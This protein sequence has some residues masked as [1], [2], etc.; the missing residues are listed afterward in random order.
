MPPVWAY[1]FGDYR[2]DTVRRRLT[3]RGG[4]AL[5]LTPKAFDTLLFLLEHRNEILAKEDLL[6]ALWPGRIV[7]ENNVNQHISMLRRALGDT[8]GEHQYIV[9][10]PGRGYRFVADVHARTELSRSSE[11]QPLALAVL[12]FM[13][14]VPEQS[15][16]A[17]ELGMADTLITRLGGLRQVI[18][19]PLSSVRRFLDPARNP[20]EAGRSLAAQAVLDGSIQR[21][22]DTLRVTVRLLDVASE[23]A[24]W[25]ATFDEPV[26]GI[27]AV[28]D[29]IAA[30]VAGALALQ[31]G[32]QE[33]LHLARPL[34]ANPEAYEHYLNGRYHLARLTPPEMLTAVGHF[35]DAIA[36]EPAFALAHV[37]LASTLF[38][39]PLAGEKPPAEHFPQAQAAARS[40]LDIEPGLAEAHAVMGWVA[41]WFDWDWN[42][43]EAHFL[44]ALELDLND[45]ESHLGYAHLLS[46]TGRHDEALEQVT[47]ARRLSPLHLLAQALEG[48]FLNHA[49]RPEAA[50]ARLDRT[51]ALESRM[52]LAHMYRSSALIAMG[53]HAEAEESARTAVAGSGRRAHAMATL[54]CALAIAGRVEEA[55]ALAGV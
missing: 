20:I 29:A 16:P 53:R 38:R 26:S 8:P 39:L 27:F 40:A 25:S 24:L 35:R 47:A 15:D 28:E 11:D 19:R 13:P 37:G 17:L 32:T 52:W 30:K 49:G 33:R 36:L 14:L 50:L 21:G 43:S 34:T 46:N 3:R 31:L 54:A 22:G 4:A 18:V 44:T 1:E 51:V 2:L 23:A 10:I 9:T 41:F 12:P 6:E 55:R 7:E 42:A 48:Q 5:P 45:A